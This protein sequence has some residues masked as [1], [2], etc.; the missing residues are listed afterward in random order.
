MKLHNNSQKKLKAYTLS[1][2]S[3]FIFHIGLPIIIIY[4]CAFLYILLSSP[5]IPGYVLS[6]M[7]RDTLEHLIMS[8]TLIFVGGFG[9]DMI[10]KAEDAKK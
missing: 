5:D 3:L 9:L 2:V 10:K 1:A 8:I 6:S 4:L 7:Y